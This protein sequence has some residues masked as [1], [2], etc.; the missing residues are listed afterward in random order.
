MVHSIELLFDERTEA[1]L[2]RDRAALGD[3]GL[4]GEG[5]RRS[6]TDRPHVSLVVAGRID[7]EARE[8]LAPLLIGLPLPVTVGA[9][10]LF[11]RKAFTLVRLIVPSMP[12]LALHAEVAQACARYLQPGPLP[13]TLPGQW[14]PHVTL[15]RRL[16]PADVAAA[17]SAIGA[18]DYT[19]TFAGMRHWDGDARVA[20]PV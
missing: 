1:A 6:A 4:P 8:A 3:A 13:H 2:R 11:G 17:L 19:G 16:A 15:C 20:H 12:L 9:P 5:P 10:M 18:R 7:D 14:T